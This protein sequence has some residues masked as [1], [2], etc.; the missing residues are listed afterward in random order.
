MKSIPIL[1]ALC[2]LA[3]SACGVGVLEIEYC[4]DVSYVSDLT[5]GI[6]RIEVWPGTPTRY[7]DGPL[8]VIAARDRVTKT[9]RFFLERAEQWY[10]PASYA[11]DPNQFDTWGN[12]SIRFFRENTETSII[13]MTGVQLIASG[14]DALTIKV[15]SPTDTAR[16]HNLLYETP[17]P[18]K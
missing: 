11:S 13:R 6:D 8:I 2:A 1:T 5:D 4:D 15:L 7:G 10:V 3:S 14:C 12:Y 17:L 16:L 18:G 9:A